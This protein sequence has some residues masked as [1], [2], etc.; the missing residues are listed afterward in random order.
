MDRTE[1]EALLAERA[2]GRRLGMIVI[3][4]PANPTNDL[5]DIGAAASLAADRATPEHRP[6]VA[7]DNTFLGPLWQH[8]LRLG[9][10]LVMYSATKYLGGHSDLI[11]GAVIGSAAVL[12]P[13]AATRTYLGTMADPWTGWLLMRSLETLQLRMTR[14]AETAGK[15]ARFLVEHPKVSKVS[16]LDLLEPGDPQYDLYRRQCLGPGAMMSFEVAGGEEGAFRF[17]DGL[18]LVKLAVSLGS[19]ESLAEHPATMTHA[20]CDPE[21]RERTGVTAGLVR[22]SV[23]VEHPDD[24]IADLAQALDRV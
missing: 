13:I 15:V 4:T 20:G 19:T 9:A 12:R 10:D 1:I 14:Q 2:P 5:F 8:P 23:G 7:V 22:L 21:E 6:L 3:E 24:L 11:A 18:R 17:L 16:Y